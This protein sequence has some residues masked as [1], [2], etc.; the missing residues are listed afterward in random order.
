MDLLDKVCIFLTQSLV[1]CD[2]LVTGQILIQYDVAN[3][4]M[5]NAI[6]LQWR[7]AKNTFC[8]K[9]LLDKLK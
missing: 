1:G 7:R 9:L 6:P 5:R 8:L 4:I 2:V 3:I